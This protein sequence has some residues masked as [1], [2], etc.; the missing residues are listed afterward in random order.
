[1]SLGVTAT[2]SYGL[3]PISIACPWVIVPLHKVSYGRRGSIS[4]GESSDALLTRA[5]TGQACMGS[6]G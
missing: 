3:P 4:A 5:C 1:M 2:R 6:A